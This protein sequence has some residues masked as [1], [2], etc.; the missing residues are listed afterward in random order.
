HDYLVNWIQL[1]IETLLFYHPAVW[2]ISARIRHERELCCDDLAV[3]ACEGAMCYAR[4]LTKL[5]KMRGATPAMALG[6]TGGALLYRIQR[7]M[8][9][10][11]GT[12]AEQYGPSRASG[13]VALSLALACLL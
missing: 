13:V 5:E 7:I 6:S 3:T 4:A 2:W 1:L 11:A 9:T 10:A 8:G 12:T